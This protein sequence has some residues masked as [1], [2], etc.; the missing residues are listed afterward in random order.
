MDN[1]FLDFLPE[2][3]R[4]QRRRRRRLRIHAVALAALAAVLAGWVALDVGRLREVRAEL[5]SVRRQ[6]AGV[7][8]Q[9]QRRAELERQMADLMLKAR[10]SR[11]LG[12]RVSA[13][14]L[15]C[16]LESLLPENMFLTDLALETVSVG[17]SRQLARAGVRGRAMPAAL[18]EAS[19]GP[20]SERRVR[21]VLTGLAPNDVAVANF[22]AQLSA[23]EIFED[24]GMG[25]TKTTN[26]RGRRAR[27]FQASVYVVR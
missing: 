26:Y 16:E 22:V 15:V 2:R 10:I 1:G 18:R 8:L 20:E 24:V 17:A 13:L 4:M 9:V 14:E 19:G 5:Q 3:I 25:Y 6:A 12:C 7:D 27:Q 23:S 21:V 11:T